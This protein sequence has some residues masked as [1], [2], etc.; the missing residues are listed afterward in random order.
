[1]LEDKPGQQ[2]QQ[3]EAQRRRNAEWVTLITFVLMLGIAIYSL[4]AVSEADKTVMDNYAMPWVAVTAGISY[5]I[6]RKGGYTRGIYVL[7]GSIAVVS[8]AYPIFADNV[9][10]QTAVGSLFLITSIAIIT[11]PSGTAGRISAAAFV[12][13]ILIIM[14]DLY[15]TGISH[16]PVTT[17]AIVITSLLS[18]IY[19]GLILSRF[20]MFSLRTKLITAFIAVSVVSVGAVALTISRSILA[21]LTVKVEQELTSVTGLTASLIAQE[22]D[23]QIDVLR[24]VSQTNTLDIGLAQTNINATGNLAELEQLDR[25][26]QAALAAGNDADPLIQSVLNHRISKELHQMQGAFPEHSEVLVTD[27]YGASVAATNR[28]SDYYQGDKE[29]WQAAYNYGQG[30]VFIGQPEYYES[31]QTLGVLIAIPVIDPETGDAAGVLRTIVHLKTFITPF[32][33][34]R[35]GQTGRSEIYMPDG[36]ELEIEKVSE[37]EYKLKIEQAPMDFAA[38]LRQNNTFMDTTHDGIPVLAGQVP[39]V[40]T[41]DSP[42]D[43]AAFGRLGWRVVTLQDRDEALQLVSDANRNM[44]VA[45]LIALLV[46]GLLAVGVAQFLIGPITRLTQTAEKVSGGDLQTRAQVESVDEIGVLAGA[47]NLM[48]DQLNQTLSGLENRV[49]ERTADV[50]R[51]QLQII[52]RAQELQSISEI[53]RTISSEQRLDILLPLITQLV[54]EKFSFYHAG[55]FF[56]DSTRRFAALQAANSE[57]GQRMLARGHHLEVGKT[58]IVGHVASTGKPRI[59]LDVGADAVYFDNP[60]LPNTRSEMALPLNFR[61]N[62]IGVLDLQSTEP[63]AFTES[64]ANTLGILA[65]QIAIA[66]ENARLFGQYQQTLDEAQTLYSQYLRTGW[67]TFAQ[68]EASIGYQ[69]SISGGRAL[70]SPVESEEIRSALQMGDV[71][72]LDG[73]DAL[74]ACIVVPV[75]LRGQTIGVLN[76]KAPT[77]NRKWNQDEINL[78]QAVSDR[79]ALAL[80]N[81]RLLQ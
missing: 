75:K 8:I 11:L 30:A 27:R 46:A 43:M 16:T 66:I 33:A 5:F 3:S 14:T 54:S 26:W 51:A 38:A 70:S 19:V 20:R 49:A 1:M 2:D 64:D 25:Q 58:G 42:E 39:L 36:R 50:E 79:L 41:A 29:W 60:D 31:I 17:S 77:K 15:V 9:G 45:G 18:V 65:D 24:V 68:Q 44:Q 80:E 28:P 63:G 78:A 59:A 72:V 34:G 76:V 21:Q 47:F 12:L 74:E 55:I 53:S 23:K 69:Q 56:V 61:G 22:L 10:W 4:F 6:V 62:T 7:L 52:R 32:E 81:A 48:T 71:L 67:T 37:S 35:F 73:P 57:G 40:R 13:G